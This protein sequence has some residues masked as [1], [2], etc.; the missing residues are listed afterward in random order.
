MVEDSAARSNLLSRLKHFTIHTRE[1]TLE[2]RFGELDGL[3]NQL[4]AEKIGS[5]RYDNVFHAY[6]WLKRQPDRVR[7]VIFNREIPIWLDGQKLG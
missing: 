7:P 1:E 2:E 3:Y 4:G 6:S 5:E